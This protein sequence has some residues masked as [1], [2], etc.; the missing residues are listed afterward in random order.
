M[1]VMLLPGGLGVY[2]SNPDRRN[3]L[4]SVTSHLTMSPIDEVTAAVERIYHD[5]SRPVFATL[6]RLLGDFD[7]AEEALHEASA[8]AMAQWPEEGIPANPVAWLVSTGRF[9]AIDSMRR[10]SRF[11]RSPEVLD[12]AVAPEWNIEEIDEK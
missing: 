4:P 12:A 9:R 6:V 5:D 7:A 3:A 10:M 11:E 2:A 1:F 8:A